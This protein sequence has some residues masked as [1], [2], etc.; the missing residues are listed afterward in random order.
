MEGGMGLP[1]YKTSRKEEHAT[2]L[3]HKS[4]PRR[5]TMAMEK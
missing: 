4:V 1:H 2:R 5:T 3:C